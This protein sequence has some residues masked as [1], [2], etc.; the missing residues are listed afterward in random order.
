VSAVLTVL[1]NQATDSLVSQWI[2]EFNDELIEKCID[3]LPP[4]QQPK[5]SW[6]HRDMNGQWD[7]DEW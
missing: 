2:M 5:E 6:Y 7:G 1:R 4:G 3:L